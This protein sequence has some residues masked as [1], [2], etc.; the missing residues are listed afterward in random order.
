MKIEHSDLAVLHLSSLQPVCDSKPAAGIGERC[1]VFS[2][3]CNGLCTDT[4]SSGSTCVG[5]KCMV[6]LRL[7]DISANA[8]VVSVS[9]SK[10]SMCQHRAYTITV[11]R[12]SMAEQFEQ[13]QVTAGEQTAPMHAKLGSCVLIAC[14]R[15]NARGPKHSHAFAMLSQGTSGDWSGSQHQQQANLCRVQYI[16]DDSMGGG[17][18]AD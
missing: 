2:N 11:P 6:R 14:G 7:D 13:C 8:C 9:M 5:A 18:A 17:Q 10:C 3:G 15:F 1:G 4:C 16:Q 12:L